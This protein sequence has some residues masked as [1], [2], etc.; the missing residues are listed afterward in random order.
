MQFLGDSNEVGELSEF[1]ASILLLR[2]F[3]VGG[4]AMKGLGRPASVRG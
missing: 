4:W 3:D 1:H 2:W